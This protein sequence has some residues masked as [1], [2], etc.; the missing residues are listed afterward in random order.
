MVPPV[1]IHNGGSGHDGACGGNLAE[2]CL[3][4]G[5]VPL[6]ATAAFLRPIRR[7]SFTFE[8]AMLHFVRHA[9]L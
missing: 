6:A 7:Q 2:L 8:M 3:A 9:V 5:M 1:E 4:A